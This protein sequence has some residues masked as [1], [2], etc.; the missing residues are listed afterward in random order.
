MSPSK[1]PS[2]HASSPAKSGRRRAGRAQR[3]NIIDP[4][5]R[6]AKLREPA[7]CTQ[8][9][10]VYLHG[11][12]AWAPRPDAAEPM[13]CQACRRI[14][15]RFPAGTVTLSGPIVAAQKDAIL[16]LLR[17]QEEAEKNE[18]P[19]NRIM[20]IDDAIANRLEIST[21][22]IHLP[23]RIGNAMKDAYKG[24]LDEHFDEGGYF[25]RVSWHRDE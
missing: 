2:E 4:Y 17:H 9:G 10:A 22:D 6:T 14:N 25:V 18:H 3:D 8:C 21:T 11:R 19:L 13:L 15:D 1:L 24:K 7:F 5:T 12:W 20:A 16:G 23:R